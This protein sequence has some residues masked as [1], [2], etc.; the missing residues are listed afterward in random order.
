MELFKVADTNKLVTDSILAAF[1][2]GQGINRDGVELTHDYA[3]RSGNHSCSPYRKV[4]TDLNSDKKFLVVSGLPMVDAYG[5]K[6][7]L[8]WRD[9]NGVIESGNNIFHSVV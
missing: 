6:H 2:A 3:L 8:E 7:E 1:L 9:K 5:Q 4:Y